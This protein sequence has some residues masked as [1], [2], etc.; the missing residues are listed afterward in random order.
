MNFEQKYIKYKTKYL[1]LK[2]IFGGEGK[3]PTLTP[4][5]LDKP[6]EP[7]PT[8]T[9]TPPPTP[10]SNLTPIPDAPAP[11]KLPLGVLI[12]LYSIPVLLV[13]LIIVCLKHRRRNNLKHNLSIMNAQNPSFIGGPP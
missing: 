8:P 4:I 3:A 6:D 12:S 10:D 5:L 9:P 11:A 13:V 1:Q 2:K 7:K